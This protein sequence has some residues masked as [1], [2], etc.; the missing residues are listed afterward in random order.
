[1]SRAFGQS[2]LAPS[3][4]DIGTAIWVPAIEI[5][6]K[7]GN[8]VVSAELPGLGEG[9]VDVQIVNDTLVIQGE[10]KDEREEEERGAR[11]TEI[12]YGRFYRAIPLPEGAQVDQAR[13]EFNNGLLRVTIPAPQ[14]PN[15]RR[16]PVQAGSGRQPQTGAQKGETEKAA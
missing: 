2:A 12:R 6:Y 15:V 11:R 3:G 10:R 4:A 7:D 14:A 13:A 1:M 16:I 8:L 9:D 5:D